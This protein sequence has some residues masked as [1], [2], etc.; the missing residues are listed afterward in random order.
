M[1]NTLVAGNTDGI[2]ELKK[3]VENLKKFIE[4]KGS[5]LNVGEGNTDS[6][7]SDKKIKYSNCWIE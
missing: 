6:L 1:S 5:Y 2:E 3:E 7:T 4:N